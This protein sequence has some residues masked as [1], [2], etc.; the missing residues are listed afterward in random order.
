LLMSNV[1]PWKRSRVVSSSAPGTPRP[2]SDGP[3]ARRI[4][5]GL[6]VPVA[7][8][9]P[10]KTLSPLS[11]RSLVEI[12]PKV[13]GVAVGVAVAVGVGVGE[14]V[15]VEE[16][17]GVAVG[18][19]EGVTRGGVGDGVAVSTGV[20]VGVGVCGVPEGVGVAMGP[21]KKTVRTDAVVLSEPVKRPVRYERRRA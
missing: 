18:V 19:G 9:P 1:P 3:I 4:T 12:F 11:T 21:G 15:G 6:P 16:G 17:S 5:L 8:S 13:P 10:I 2:L 7:I 14:T 20:G